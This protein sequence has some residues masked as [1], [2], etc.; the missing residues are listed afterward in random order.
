MPPP[1]QTL[2]NPG[3]LPIEDV[4]ADVEREIASMMSRQDVVT[5]LLQAN[6]IVCSAR[7][8]ID[9]ADLPAGSLF[10]APFLTNLPRLG[11]SGELGMMERRLPPV[12]DDD[13]DDEAAME[14]DEDEGRMM[15]SL[16]SMEDEGEEGSDEPG[17]ARSNAAA[18]IAAGSGAAGAKGT[19]ARRAAARAAGG[20][21]RPRGRQRW[22]R[23]E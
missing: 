7:S 23:W 16:G 21:V 8:S 14:W 13:L 3:V 11:S 10:N 1:F 4:V 2:L 5:S 19:P 12:L 6:G 22:Q 18:L 20:I 9:G 17:G 15:M